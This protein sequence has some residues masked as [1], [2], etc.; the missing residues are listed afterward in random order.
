MTD[1]LYA[2]NNITLED[3]VIVILF[4]NLFDLYSTLLLL[5][6]GQVYETNFLLEIFFEKFGYINTLFTAK[7]VASLLVMLIVVY[8]Y[9]ISPQLIKILNIAAPIIL[10]IYTMV[11]MWHIYLMGLYCS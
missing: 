10:I 1:K 8:K 2:K 3:M 5:S 9:K 4:L 7:A 11:M 6:T